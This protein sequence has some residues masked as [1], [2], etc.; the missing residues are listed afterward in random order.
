MAWQSTSLKVPARTPRVFVDESLGTQFVATLRRLGY[1]AV[2][3]KSDDTRILLTQ[4]RVFLDDRIVPLNR[5]AGVVVLLGGHNETLL[6]ALMSALP[7]IGKER[8]IW[9]S[10]RVVVH[11]DGRLT[12]TAEDPDSGR[13]QV[14]RYKLRIAGSPLVWSQ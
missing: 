7:V 4:R 5:N 3:R 6:T 1:D 2:E 13:R 12:V 8:E 9:Q 10:T 14:T 11:E